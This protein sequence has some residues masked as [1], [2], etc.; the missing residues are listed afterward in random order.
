MTAAAVQTHQLRAG[1]LADQTNRPGPAARAE[2]EPAAAAAAAAARSPKKKLKTTH[3]RRAAAHSRGDSLASDLDTDCCVI[4]LETYSAA[5]PKVHTACGHGYHLHCIMGWSDTAGSDSKCP[6]CY[7]PLR[8]E[9][10]ETDKLLSRSPPPRPRRPRSADRPRSPGRVVVLRITN[11]GRP[12]LGSQPAFQLEMDALP[13]SSFAAARPLS[14]SSRRAAS[15]GRRAAVYEA[16]EPGR[17]QLQGVRG[18]PSPRPHAPGGPE[19]PL[20]ALRRSGTAGRTDPAGEGAGGRGGGGL[21]ARL[22][23]TLSCGAH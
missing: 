7:A 11:P 16:R 9:D 17:S 18:V 6:L 4:C 5:N 19:S 12:R 15:L 13:S 20:A 1:P 14:G 23:R 8:L 2:A 21:F 10:E 22:L 3:A